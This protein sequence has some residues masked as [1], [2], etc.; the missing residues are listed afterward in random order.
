M[1]LPFLAFGLYLQK[2]I[3]HVRRK[4]LRRGLAIDRI[5]TKLGQV[6]LP[7]VGFALLMRGRFVVELSIVTCD[8]ELLHQTERGEDL[9]V[10]EENF[11]EDLFVKQ[12]Q[13][14]WPKPNEID[15][16]YCD[17]DYGDCSNRAKPFENALKHLLYISVEDADDM[18]RNT[19]QLDSTSSYESLISRVYCGLQMPGRS[20]SVLSYLG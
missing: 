11:G 4:L 3:E 17:R 19:L 5:L 16:E 12:V 18:T 6:A 9:R 13:A 15:Q 8:P 7:S 2:P 1:P 20:I 10:I 14:P